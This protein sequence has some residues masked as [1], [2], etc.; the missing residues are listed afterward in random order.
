MFRLIQQFSNTEEPILDIA[1]FL[2]CGNTS[3][4]NKL[5]LINFRIPAAGMRNV[6][7]PSLNILTKVAMW[8]KTKVLQ[9]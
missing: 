2:S 3:D 9:S 5:R 6:P 4:R 8:I 1:G 7:M